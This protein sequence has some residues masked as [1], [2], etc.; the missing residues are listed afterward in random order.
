MASVGISAPCDVRSWFDVFFEVVASFVIAAT[1]A[2]PRGW[3]TMTLGRRASSCRLWVAG[4]TCHALCLT[5]LTRR[6]DRRRQCQ[7][8]LNVIQLMPSKSD[9]WLPDMVPL[10]PTFARRS[11][12]MWS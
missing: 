9:G 11:V 3:N 10:G 2:A 5:G 12:V 6:R 4:A 1:T 7:M 8:L